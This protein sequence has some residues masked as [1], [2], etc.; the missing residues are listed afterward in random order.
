MKHFI[1]VVL[2]ILGILSA[3]MI[4]VTS[5]NNLT[6]TRLAPVQT[7]SMSP[8]I[9]WGSLVVSQK[10]PESDVTV[11]SSVIIDNGSGASVMGRVLSIAPYNDQGYYS[12][13]LQGDN[14]TLPEAFPYKVKNNTYLIQSSVPVLGV[15][16]M[17]LTSIPGNILLF[18]VTIILTLIVLNKVSR[19]STTSDVDTVNNT[20]EA[21]TT[22]TETDDLDILERMF[23][24]STETSKH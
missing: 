1:L 12:V 23:E 8:E 14:R 20:D 2:S 15:P 19:P 16:L 5:I 24:E 22:G 3:G 6:D 11:G 9:R 21:N 13:M 7:N 4:T 17:A 18:L 10:V